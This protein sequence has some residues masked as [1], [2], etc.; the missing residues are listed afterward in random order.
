MQA[1][2]SPS[3]LLPTSN[4]APSTTQN[5]ANFPNSTIFTNTPQTR[6]F[7]PPANLQ[8]ATI[9]ENMRF[10]PILCENKRFEFCDFEHPPSQRSEVPSCSGG[11]SPPN[12]ELF[13]RSRRAAPSCSGVPRAIY[14]APCPVRNS[15]HSL[16]RLISLYSSS[17]SP[18]LIHRLE[19]LLIPTPRGAK[20]HSVPGKTCSRMALAKSFAEASCTGTAGVSPASVGVPPTDL[21]AGFGKHH[22]ATHLRSQEHP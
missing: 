1:P 6:H 15:V 9:G 8:K 4:C 19:K 12:S 17:V 16:T 20:R 2:I 11:V 10:Y 7:P 3:S 18:A 14:P 5:T 22:A 13:L 21:S